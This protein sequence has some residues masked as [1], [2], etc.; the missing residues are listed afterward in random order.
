MAIARE[1]IFGPVLT[2]SSYVG[3][4]S[5]LALANDNPYG[6][7]AGVWTKDPDRATWFARRLRAGT[8]HI[9]G[10]QTGLQHPLG[11]Y[12]ASGIGRELGREGLH[13]YLETKVVAGHPRI[14]QNGP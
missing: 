1:E 12:K 3:D 14:V 6:L 4:H 2:V 7:A 8:V 9:N 5:A 10:T 11:G 13:H